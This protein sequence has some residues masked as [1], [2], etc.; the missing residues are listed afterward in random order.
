M[1]TIRQFPFDKNGQAS[2]VHVDGGSNWP[3]IYLINSDTDIYVGETTSFERR[4]REHLSN[5]RKRFAGFTE[6][7]FAYDGTENKSAILD[8]ESNLIRLY[9]ADGKFRRV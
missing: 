4:F 2:S 5:N 9:S 6:I 1:F 3:V 8:Y 7:R